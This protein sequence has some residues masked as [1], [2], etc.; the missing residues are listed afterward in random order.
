MERATEIPG[1]ISITEEAIEGGGLRL[2]FEIEEGREEQFFAAFG[3]TAGDSAG[4]QRVVI[5][6]I[7]RLLE[8]SGRKK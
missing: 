3:L 1:L 7:E 5:E 4:F 2:H 8:M 6:A